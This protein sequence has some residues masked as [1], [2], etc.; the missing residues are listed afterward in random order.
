MKKILFQKFIKDTLK[1]FITIAFVLGL[2]VWVIQAVNFLDF[3]TEDGHSLYVYFSYSALNF[4]KII[5]RILPFVF[6][7]SLFYQILKYESKNELLIFWTNGVKKIQFINVVIF[8]S[9]LVTIFQIFLGSFISPYSQNEARTFIRTSNVD[10]FP[11]LIKEGKFIDTV[12]G[13][14]IF[15]ESKDESG[16]YNNI[17]LKDLFTKKSDEQT[18]ESFQII[19]AKKGRLINSNNNRFFE[20]YEGEMI[21]KE[22][23]KITNFT[24]E[25]IN[26]NLSKYTS[27]ST[28]YP[29]I[30]EVPSRDII[31]CLNLN[32][33]NKISDF[34]NTKFLQC[35]I[36][37]MNAIKQEFLKRFYKPFYL[38]LLSLISCL[39]ILKSK[40]N[41]DFDKFKIFLFLI[42][43][44]VIVISELSLRFSSS[45]QIGLYF[46]LILPLLT[47]I[48]I[49]LSLKAKVK[50]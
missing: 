15:I 4:P 36:E 23:K 33:R 24:F 22:N 2:I 35:K 12:S 27:K 49:Y 32:Y 50:L 48:T 37:S 34:D 17:F 20:L 38:P 21:N 10:F 42:I 29:K 11:A 44:F 40:E 31:E 3:V 13:L 30:Q 46:F 43:F 16:N 45:G 8:Y 41:D 18:E 6:F 1:L 47:F 14:T 5:H 7:I 25:K 39:L 28:T 26:F 9:L 19:Y